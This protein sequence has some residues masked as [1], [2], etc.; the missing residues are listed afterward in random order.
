MFLG[1]LCVS[2]YFG[3]KADIARSTQNTKNLLIARGASIHT[4]IPLSVYKLPMLFFTFSE[5]SHANSTEESQI[6]WK[7]IPVRNIGRDDV[8]LFLADYGETSR[9]TITAA[10]ALL[11][12]AYE[13][14]PSK[15]DVLDINM[16]Y[17][18]NVGSYEDR[19]AEDTAAPAWEFVLGDG[20]TRYIDAYPIK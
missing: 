13:I 18:L 16:V 9:K 7:N 11:I 15:L 8:Q 10:E 19:I 12:L 1:G 20:E 17:L 5:E 3:E 2:R 14:G 4:D 6:E